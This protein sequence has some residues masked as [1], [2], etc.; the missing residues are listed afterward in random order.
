MAVLDQNAI[1]PAIHDTWEN[2]ENFEQW[3]FLHQKSS[4]VFKLVAETNGTGH[5]HEEIKA[6]RTYFGDA[7]WDQI[8]ELW[9]VASDAQRIEFFVEQAGF[10]QDQLLIA[11]NEISNPKSE[12]QEK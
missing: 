4:E 9:A 5:R 2:L 11:L 3:L 7:H 8:Q 12:G 6:C 10:F 1:V